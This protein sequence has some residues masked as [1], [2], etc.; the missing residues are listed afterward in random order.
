[1]QGNILQLTFKYKYDV[2]PSTLYWVTPLL[3]R[4]LLVVSNCGMCYILFQA[5]LTLA[6]SPLGSHVRDDTCR[7]VQKLVQ[8]IYLV[9]TSAD[10]SIGDQL[11]VQTFYRLVQTLVQKTNLVQTSADA[12]IGDQLGI[13]QCRRQYRRSTSFRLVQWLV[14]EII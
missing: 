14:Q 5:L 2:L 13:G 8:Q 4:W 7:L 9:Q 10:A 11:H 3:R 6:I 1:M 12:S